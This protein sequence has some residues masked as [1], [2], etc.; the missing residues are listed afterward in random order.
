MS[1]TTVALT[2]LLL[3]ATLAL[4]QTQPVFVANF[5]EGFNAMGLD[6]PVVAEPEG[7]PELARGRSG[8]ALKSGPD[9]GYLRYPTEGIISTEGG[10]IEMWVQA[11]DWKPTE[12]K[13]HVFF[14]VRGEGALYLYKYYQG[15]NLLMLSC[16]NTGG[17]YFSSP[18]KMHWQPG[19]WHHIAGTWSPDGVLSYIDG[20]PAAPLPSAGEL[21]VSLG[22]T[23]L[24]GDHPWHIERTT[25]SLIDDVRIYDRALSPEHIAAHFAGNYDFAAPLSEKTVTLRYS[26]DADTKRVSVALSTAADVPDE[27]V[28]ARVAL[29]LKGGDLPA[30]AAVVHFRAGRASHD[31]Q[32]KS[33]EPGEFDVVAA[34]FDGD[35]RAVELRRPLIIPAIDWRG[36]TIGRDDRVI[37]PWTPLQAGDG[38]VRCWGREYTL[39]DAGLPAQM[40]SAG[41]DLLAGP[42]QVRLRSGETEAVWSGGDHRRRLSDAH[43]R[44]EVSG[45]LRGTVGD[46]DARLEISSWTE[47][48]G[49][50]YLTL[51]L[52]EG[53]RMPGD[54]LSLEIPL[55]TPRAVYRHRWARSWAGVTGNLP[56]GGGVVDK[57]AFLPYYWLGD[58]DR[59]LFWFCASD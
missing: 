54:S 11:L 20:K 24:I 49:L 4:C 30:N 6:G 9:T 19:E 44:L 25:S 21:P 28:S 38:T 58:N 40:T 8:S 47:Y 29:V 53:A 45:E 48:D 33:L 1:R 42:V 5:D 32:L 57:S 37:P 18:S 52:P 22:E 13:F 56:A 12:D 34:I 23:F 2:A 43:T 26:L 39:T 3:T 55:R 14:D 27:R 59:G 15:T 10:T 46:A 50:M 41:E 7:A 16:D 31:L 35:T 17:P 36:N 51:S